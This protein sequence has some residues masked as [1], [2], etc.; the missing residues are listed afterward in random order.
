MNKPDLLDDGAFWHPTINKVKGGYTAS[1][2]S[3]LYDTEEQAGYAMDI[4]LDAITKSGSGR[5][6]LR[7]TR[8]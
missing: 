8:H 2:E 1:L 4:L 5:T 3:P 6:D 7:E